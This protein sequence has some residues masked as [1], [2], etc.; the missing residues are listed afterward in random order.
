MKSLTVSLTLCM[1][2]I[3]LELA[4]ASRVSSDLNGGGQPGARQLYRAG[5]A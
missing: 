2:G 5:T 3:G 1:F 4:E